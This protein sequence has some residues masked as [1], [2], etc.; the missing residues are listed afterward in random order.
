MIKKIIER[1]KKTSEL[2]KF[3]TK[4]VIL[5]F[6]WRIFRKYM[7][8]WG[9]YEDLTYAFAALYLKVS[10]FFL[11][12]TGFESLVDYDTNK[13]WIKG[14]ENSIEVVY[15]CLGIN[16]FVVFAIFIVIYPGK[17][18]SKLWYLPSGLIIIF[19]LNAMR[20]SAMAY[21]ADVKPQNFD[22]F[23]H[24]IFQGVIYIAIFLMWFGFVR[25]S[26]KNQK[27]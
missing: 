17:L 13:L 2:N 27:A 15:D 23:H 18:I 1:Y 19:I 5:Y 25:L 6:L 22:V 14:S 9:Q 10:D 4:G 12:I 7:L 24:F 20:M 3:L 11:R 16:L 21:I 26:A 8:L